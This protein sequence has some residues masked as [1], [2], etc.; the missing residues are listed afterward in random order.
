MIKKILFLS[1]IIFLLFLSFTLTF[2]ETT[3][4]NSINKDIASMNSFNNSHTVLAEYGTSSGCPDCTPV[5]DY[6]YTLYSS[7]EY[8][9]YYVSL[10]I[11]KNMKAANRC[12]ELDMSGFPSVHFDGGYRNVTENQGSTA[13]YIDALNDSQSRNNY[14]PVHNITLNV[15]VGWIETEKL[16]IN[17]S[18]I[19]NECCSGSIY[20]GR[21]RVYITEINSRWNDQS[22]EPY[23]FGM[24][25]YAFNENITVVH[26]FTFS[27]TTI[28][29]G[30][31]QGYD[32]DPE[33]IMVIAAVYDSKW[34][35]VDQTSASTILSDMPDTNI[36]SGPVGVIED[37]D[38]EFEWIG[39]DENTPTEE[40][41][42]SYKLEPYETEWSD[43]SLDKNTAYH[44]LSEGYYIFMV[45]TKNNDGKE[46]P[47]PD[48][49]SF[50]V[51]QYI[52]PVMNI[53]KPTKALYINNKMAS[54]PI[55]LIIGD[56]DIEVNASDECGIE[57]IEFYVDDHL[58]HTDYNDP[59][60]C[61]TWDGRGFFKRHTIKA[62]AYDTIGNSANRE[63]KVWKLF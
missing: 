50:T 51:N 1:S 21:L 32:I 9:F 38:V 63:I 26:G 59:Y 35:Y 58:I 8:D 57:K 60:S 47:Y 5:S 33:N 40:L 19:N 61:T 43:W 56:I 39:V 62:I 27:L 28:W 15:D 48:S 17:I 46:D 42:F 37:T 10:V 12:S 49:R 6:L 31:T 4:S 54:F 2:V 7:R 24:L 22:G 45:K 13:S 18:I 55:S 14:F 25:D 16:D 36:T 3:Q 34:N 52:P 11:D 44:D 20:D 53:T 41:L 29:D 30:S 23:H